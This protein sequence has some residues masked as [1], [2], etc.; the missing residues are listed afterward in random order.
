VTVDIM[1]AATLDG[2]I[3]TT[4]GDTGW[5]L[6]DALFKQ[7]AAQYGCVA[8]GH[9]TFAEVYP[10]EGVQHIVLSKKPLKKNDK[11]DVHFVDSVDAALGRA[12]RLGFDKLLVIGGAKTNRS[13]LEA[14]VVKHVFADIHPIN[15]GK[16]KP[17]FDGFKSKLDFTLISNTWNDAGFMHAEY[18][19]ALK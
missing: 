1:L 19:V 14:G 10:L 7:T 6:D 2:F 3:A 18:N 9:T 17:M 8:V 15:L 4:S 5:V 11:P 12:M 16:G 13:F